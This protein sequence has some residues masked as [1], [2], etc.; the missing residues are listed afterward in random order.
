MGDQWA[1]LRRPETNDAPLRNELLGRIRGSQ[2]A[3]FGA[4]MAM[5]VAVAWG[6]GYPARVVSDSLIETLMASDELDRAMWASAFVA[7][8]GSMIVAAAA[9]TVLVDW[10]RH[11]RLPKRRIGLGERVLGG[12][13]GVCPVL[14]GGP[15]LGAIGWPPA[16]LQ[17]DVARD[18]G[19]YATYPINLARDLVLIIWIVWSTWIGAQAVMTLAAEE[20][21]P[22]GV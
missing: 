14:I 17:I 18:V 5:L 20:A 16:H 11:G 6:V 10:R 7:V 1:W 9:W 15:I 21:L 19:T 3:A 2:A 13:F 12:A 22:E 8:F 4:V